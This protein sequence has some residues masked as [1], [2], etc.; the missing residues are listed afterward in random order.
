MRWLYQWAVLSL[1][2]IISQMENKPS[3]YKES[4]KVQNKYSNSSR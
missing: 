3:R 4:L 2:T 1:Q